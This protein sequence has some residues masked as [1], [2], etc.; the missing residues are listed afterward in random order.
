M[1]RKTNTKA[2]TKRKSKVKKEKESSLVFNCTSCAQPQLLVQGKRNILC[3]PQLQ[4]GVCREC[5]IFAHADIIPIDEEGYE[6]YCRWCSELGN[7]VCCDECKTPFCEE[8][9]SRS[10]G[11]EYYDSLMD[12][13]EWKCFICEPTAI[14]SLRELTKA[15]LDHQNYND[16]TDLLLE[17]CSA[18]FNGDADV[19]DSDREEIIKERLRLRRNNLN[20]TLNR[21]KKEKKEK[22]SS[23][24]GSSDLDEDSNEEDDKEDDKVIKEIVNKRKKS[25][26]DVSDSDKDSIKKR[27]KSG[28][29][30]EYES[31]PESPKK[32]KDSDD[33]SLAKAVDKLKN[34]D[35]DSKPPKITADSDEESVPSVDVSEK[36]SAKEKNTSDSDSV[37]S[38]ETLDLEK[39]SKKH[40]RQSKNAKLKPA[41]PKTSDISGS[42]S[43]LLEKKKKEPRAKLSLRKDK[44]S[45]S[46]SSNKSRSSRNKSRKPK[47]IVSSDENSDDSD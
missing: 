31:S 2:P 28:S 33:D 30:S 46:G 32:V 39:P 1:V 5:L 8:C 35:D 26:S 37:A 17:K 41:D 38:N 34:S 36:G 21:K 19:N 14:E 9:I 27:K 16:P 7:L 6:I 29:N 4:V 25:A 3:H 44:K 22:E 10:I 45:S 13:E 11:P 24:E 47:Y 20:D 43:E 18:I 40:N 15:A 23:E 12:V 42:D